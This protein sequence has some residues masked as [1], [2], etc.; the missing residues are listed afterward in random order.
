MRIYE[1]LFIVQ[2][3]L[4]EEALANL[5]SGAQQAI[6]NNG[7][8]VINVEQMGRRRLAY[9]IKH[10]LEGVYVLLHARM[11]QQAIAELER[12]LRLSESILRYLLI[13]V[14]APTKAPAAE[15]AGTQGMGTAEIE[16]EAGADADEDV[17]A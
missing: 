5:V 8:E 9:P 1:L 17:E 13:H 2:P 10:R 12:F 4:D 7:G 6:S 14:E 11:E 3:E 16:P 15:A